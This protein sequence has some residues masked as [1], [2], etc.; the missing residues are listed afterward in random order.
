MAEEKKQEKEKINKHKF[1]FEV[2]LY[3]STKL[4]DLEDEFDNFFNGDVDAYNPNGFDTTYGIEIDEI[5]KYY[6]YRREW[7]HPNFKDYYAI[8]LICKRKYDILRFF[9]V[10]DNENIIKVGQ[11]PSV[12]DIQY[13]EI[14]KKYDK[15]L[16]KQ[17]LHD[18]KKSIG[19]MAHGAGAG[20]LVYLR[21]IFENII[22]NTFEK[23][24]SVL[25]I[26][27]E[28]F[29]AKKM[30]EKVGFLKDFLPSQLVEMK[31]VYGILSKGVHELSEEE[32]LAF[33][34]ALKLSI[35]LILDQRIEEEA[36]NKKDNETKK[37]IADIA[38]QINDK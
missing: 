23:H 30:G 10:I 13:A 27:D 8:S 21:R 24:K 4:E 26:S 18:L 37:A 6:Q 9:I 20:S 35:I 14:A 11:Y 12:A 29:K 28:E 15:V 31:A 2:P 16:P 3:T 19:L 7:H 5:R 25:K 32:C 33:F 17:D 34:P 22:L 36:K 38:K 1:F